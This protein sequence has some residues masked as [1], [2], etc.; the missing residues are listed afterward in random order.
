M[1]RH[2]VELFGLTPERADDLFLLYLDEEGNFPEAIVS[3][4]ADSDLSSR[5]KLFLGY[6]LGVMSMISLQDRGPTHTK[7]SY[8][9]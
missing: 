2:A 7:K 6:V 5:E 8:I 1:L 9:H 3:L 4:V